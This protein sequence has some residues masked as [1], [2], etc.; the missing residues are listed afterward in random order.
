MINNLTKIGKIFGITFL[1]CAAPLASNN[2]L[3]A[4]DAIN[5]TS[6]TTDAKGNTTTS[7]QTDAVSKLSGATL[8]TKAAEDKNQASSSQTTTEEQKAEEAK[9]VDYSG[10]Y[11]GVKVLPNTLTIYCKKNAEEL[12]K[13]PELVG[14]C[15]NLYVAAMNNSDAAV[16]SEGHKDYQLL[17][18]EATIDSLSLALN[19]VAATT[20]YEDVQNDM[21]EKSSKGTTEREDGASIS[22]TTSVSTDVINSL[23]ELYANSLMLEAFRNLQEIDASAIDE[24]AAAEI[25]R[26]AKLL[27][28]DANEALGK[29]LT[30]V[31]ATIG[32][33]QAE[34][35][36][37]GA[38]EPENYDEGV[39]EEQTMDEDK[40]DANTS[41]TST[42]D[43]SADES[44]MTKEQAAAILNDPNATD[45]QTDAAYKI[46]YGMS[47]VHMDEITING[48]DLD[49]FAKM[50]PEEFAQNKAEYDAVVASFTEKMNAEASTDEEIASSQRMLDRLS[51]VEK[52][53]TEAL[54][55]NQSAATGSN[56]KGQTSGATSV[57]GDNA[58]TQSSSA[59]NRAQN[60][61]QIGNILSGV[62]Q[63][64]R[65]AANVAQQ[66]GNAGQVIRNTVNNYDISSGLGRTFSLGGARNTS[67]QNSATTQHSA[68]SQSDT[69]SASASANSNKDSGQVL[70]D[71][72][73][74]AIN[75]LGFK[76]QPSLDELNKIA[77]SKDTT[78][79]QK[80]AAEDAMAYIRYKTNNSSNLPTPS[81]NGI[82]D[83]STA[84]NKN[85]GPIIT[86]GIAN[87]PQ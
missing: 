14:L 65:G 41:E 6:T 27:K 35:E 15:L 59:N 37:A 51:N 83:W 7:S 9:D 43:Q 44:N 86:N 18:S 46:L 78:D 53:Q 48:T 42:T 49:K 23:R 67:N 61:Q 62:G 64:A 20:N 45:E 17:M 87:W 31:T 22:N 82:V 52:T 71:S 21:A 5:V 50:S 60:A 26:R 1:L 11:N 19:K 29:S 12:V 69:S 85:N 55:A 84:G 2:A 68:T 47:T 8:S 30:E 4:D 33:N 66:G 13:N 75:T 38:D 74:A 32:E 70:Q 24:M 58:K 16:R 54:A 81:E 63:V 28:T 73:D 56:N 79:A 36:D 57:S 3:A 72:Y 10:V 25:E 77:T 39:A 76:E 80:E 34:A 40:V